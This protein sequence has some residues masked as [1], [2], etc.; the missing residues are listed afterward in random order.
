MPGTINYLLNIIVPV[1]IKHTNSGINV[2]KLLSYFVFILYNRYTM[3]NGQHN[4]V[5]I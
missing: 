3:N 4:S 5:I 1:V 2:N